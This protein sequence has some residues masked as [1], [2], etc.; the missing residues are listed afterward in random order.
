MN[1][2]VL[3]GSAAICVAIAISC[4]QLW[5]ASGTLTGVIAGFPTTLQDELGNKLENGRL[6]LI[7]IDSGN[8]GIALSNGTFSI[9]GFYNASDDYF[10]TALGTLDTGPGNPTIAN[11]SGTY[12]SVT[13]LDPG[14]PFY[15]VW[16]A[17]DDFGDTSLEGGDWY[18]LTRNLDWVLPSDGGT[19]TGTSPATG[20]LA[21][22]Q[23]Q[24][25]PEPSTYALIVMGL[26]IVGGLRFR[27]KQ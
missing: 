22:N 18:G 8:N 23:V 5:A 10:L 17:D 13:G 19:F 16:F 20:G 21:L 9:Q 1:I 25:I 2:S 7:V 14:D 12:S 6:A 3:R 26:A 24:P 11:G 15:V 4:G 27:R